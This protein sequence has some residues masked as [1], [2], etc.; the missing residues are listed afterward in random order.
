MNQ[1][2]QV[3][4]YVNKKR[5]KMNGLEIYEFMIL[6]SFKAVSTEL[7]FVMI[8]ENG[9][10]IKLSA[11]KFAKWLILNIKSKHQKSIDDAI[12]NISTKEKE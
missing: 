10:D 7:K 8:N 2:K 11:D 12:N 6:E 9:I 5:W 4:H 1:Q 3:Q